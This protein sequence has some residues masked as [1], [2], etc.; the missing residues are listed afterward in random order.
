MDPAT[1]FALAIKAIA[2]MITELSRGQTDA[3]KQQ[4]W[5]WY[6]A[7]VSALR[8]LLHLEG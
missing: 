4:M 8:K 6:V 2:E 1:A 3:Q 5:E 7:D